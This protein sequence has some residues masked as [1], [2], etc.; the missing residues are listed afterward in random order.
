MKSKGS[1]ND[2]LPAAL[3][4]YAV[5]RQKGMG[6]AGHDSIPATYGA[7]PEHLIDLRY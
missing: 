2:S 1:E 7:S 6:E 3:L 5:K 4:G